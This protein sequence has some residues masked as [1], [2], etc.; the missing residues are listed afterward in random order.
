VHRRRHGGG[1]NFRGLRQL[2]AHAEA[3]PRIDRRELVALAFLTALGCIVRLAALGQPIRYDEA[4]TWALFSGRSWATIVSWYPFPNN[5]VFF[6]L[7]AKATGSLAPYA[8]WAF[9]LPAFLAGV[10]IV[11]LTWLVGR[12]LAGRDTALVGAALATGSMPLVLYSVNARGHTIV[13]VASLVLILLADRLRNDASWW[14]GWLAFA[15]VGALGLYTVPVMIYPLGSVGLWI[16]LDSLRRDHREAL[17]ILTALA[18]TTLLTVLLAWLLYSPIIHTAGLQAIT[19]GKL[20]QPLPWRFFRA[21]QPAFW[22]ELAETWV[23]PLEW[24][25]VPGVFGL[26]LLGLR[27]DAGVARAS[28][29]L[30]TIV[31]CL[32]LFLLSHRTPFVRFWLFVLPLFLLVVARGITRL[33]ARLRWTARWDG[34]WIACGLAVVVSTIALVTRAAEV[35]DDTGTF[36]SAPLVTA[37]LA[38]ELRAGDRVLAPIPNNA[39]LLYYFGQ[40]GLDTALLNTAPAATKR[41]FVVL[42]PASGQTLAWAVQAGIIDPRFFQ[43]PTPLLRL[44]DAEVWRSERR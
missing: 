12:R 19:G 41:A 3:A 9:R 13:C 42:N 17:R 24:M 33:A 18:A 28:F 34:V 35:T 8:P 6:S 32:G 20:A 15:V 2:T 40:S 29:A 10:A 27:R 26:A 11:P 5:H 23:A 37:L 22:L 4:V 43:E 1:G 38:R 7:A 39:P 36:R 44:P 31:W 21:A 14:T 25:W 30:A 16:A